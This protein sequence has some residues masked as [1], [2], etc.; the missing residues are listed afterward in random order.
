MKKLI[1]CAGLIMVLGGCSRLLLPLDATQ[2]QKDRATCADAKAWVAMAD[3]ALSQ[4]G[5]GPS[6]VQY[7]TI[8]RIG[9]QAGVMSLC[10]EGQ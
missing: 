8:A 5:V 9:A 4:P 3:E 10:R 6:V 7:W 1:V 2:E